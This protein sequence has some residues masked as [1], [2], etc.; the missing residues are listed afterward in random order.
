MTSSPTVHVTLRWWEALLVLIAYAIPAVLHAP[1]L[2]L[3]TAI[4]ASIGFAA[5]RCVRI[6][7]HLL[8]LKQAEV[9]DDDVPEGT[10]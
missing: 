1:G 7:G 9:F 4:G 8:E 10:A 3:L 6:L 5:W 2:S